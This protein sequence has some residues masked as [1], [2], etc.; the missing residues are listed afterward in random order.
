LPF[1]FMMTVRDK[2]I[3]YALSML[4][5]VLLFS[6]LF[7]VQ[8]QRVL[9]EK[10]GHLT[11][12]SLELSTSWLDEVLSGAVR[13]SALV[14]SDYV[15]R[16]F[17]LEHTE[18]A[19]EAEFTEQLLTT[20]KRLEDILASDSRATSIW[21]YFAE[22]NQVIS[23]RF[24]IYQV[25]DDEALRWLK[26]QREGPQIRS[27][28]Y[29]DESIL[30][31]AGSLYDFTQTKLSG[32]LQ[33]SFIRS[34][35][36]MGSAD[37]P[38]IVGVGY[39]EYTLHDLLSEA[40]D[41]TDA[42][43]LLINQNGQPV[44]EYGE[45]I[46][47]F[48][49]EGHALPSDEERA[50]RYTIRDGWLLN[51]S[52]SRLTGWEIVSL[53]P[54]DRYMGDLQRLNLITA[55]LTV[56]VLIFAIWTA[57]ALTQSVH[58]PLRML[59]NG[60]KQMESGQL[61]VRME[62]NRNDEF[63]L[64]AEGFNR[65]AETQHNLINTVFEER[66]AKNEAELTFLTAQINPHFLYNTL[67]ALYAQAKKVD[68]RLA[69]S[70]LAMS[71]FF[72]LSLNRGKDTATIRETM[73][74]I[75]I[76]I[77]FMNLRNP[78]KYRLETFIDAGSEEEEIPVLLIQPIVENAVKHGLELIQ[79]QGVIRV[80]V[81]ALKQ[82]LLIMVADNGVGMNEEALSALRE[83]VTSEPSADWYQREANDDGIQGSGYA[84]RNIYRRLQLKYG[85]DRFIFAIE[86]DPGQGMTTMIR[87][88]RKVDTSS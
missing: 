2:L 52:K 31:H 25:T 62:H 3:L 40:A 63:G 36:G 39:L 56:T 46:D 20:Q 4:I 87:I 33:V 9:E 81:T 54:L 67:G 45:W 61:N 47:A 5:P 84:L 41:Q 66:I 10:A 11:D 35:P 38:V 77:Q 86:S 76:Y 27:W 7:W 70:L 88:P 51:A 43:L 48:R 65:M 29:P 18:E 34:V 23:T 17:I 53:A 71:R 75:E 78:G 37:Y 72:R 55:A 16:N 1:R 80:T 69:E 21:I 32:N 49:A 59:L 82:D 13:L 26:G 58:K 19:I 28:I 74:H 15:I 73:E 50:E 12:E 6:A 85:E 79:G 8:S 42:S 14:E 30:K 24:G 57:R 22:T 83:H 44:L 60:M 68:D 64:V